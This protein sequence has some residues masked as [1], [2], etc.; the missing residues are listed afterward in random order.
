MLCNLARLIANCDPGFPE[1]HHRIKDT[2]LYPTVKLSECGL[3]R[4]PGDNAICTQTPATMTEGEPP[5]TLATSLTRNTLQAAKMTVYDQNFDDMDN[6]M[7]A[8][9]IVLML[10]TL[11]S[12]K[13]IREY[14]V[15]QSRVAEPSLRSWKDHITPAALGLLRWIIASNRSCIVQVEKCPG[16]VG[17]ESSIRSNERCSNVPKDW[18]QFRF[19]QGA[20]DKE[21]RFLKSL[22]DQ[23]CSLSRKY[24]TLFAFHG[25]PTPNWHSIIRH[26]LD[27]KDTLNGRAYGHGVYHALQQGTSSHY[28]GN[29]LVCP[30]PASLIIFS[31]IVGQFQLYWPQSDLKIRSVMSLN[32]IVNCPTQFQ[33]ANPY[34]VVQH[35]DWI[36]CR[37]L[38]VQTDT[39][40]ETAEPPKVKTRDYE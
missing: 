33:S 23:K 18:V 28:A 36:Q 6:Q 30:S 8:E 10:D 3:T 37:Y 17:N 9:A 11:S 20:P 16:Q 4:R 21:Q 34:I 1:I 19:A 40:Q 31:L 38:L 14:L 32:E 29:I 15:E 7:K 24:P 5:F 25:S 35:V 27:F 26:G 2:S 39:A 12:I 13:D 22:Q